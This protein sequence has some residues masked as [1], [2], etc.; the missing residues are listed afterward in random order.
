M[1]VALPVLIPQ[2]LM[3]GPSLPPVAA[4]E[5]PELQA[6]TIKTRARTTIAP[7]TRMTRRLGLDASDSARMFIG[8]WLRAYSSPN[9]V[10]M[11]RSGWSMY[12]HDGRG[13]PEP[14]Q[15]QEARHA[16][17]AMK[18]SS[19]RLSTQLRCQLVFSA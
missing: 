11:R 1:D 15:I 17:T 8:R 2:M 18:R 4:G 3:I 12:R 16:T 14:R 13:L 19:S 7:I 5:R 9:T 6:E 10:D